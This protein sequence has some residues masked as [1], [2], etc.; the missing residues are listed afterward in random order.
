MA[1]QGAGVLQRE[2]LDVDDVRG[3]PGGLHRRLA[4]LDVLG[5]GR[6]QQHVQHVGILVGGTD[7]LVVV[8]DLFHREGDVL[9]GLHLDLTLEFVF[10]EGLRH[11]DDFG[12]RGIAADRDRRQAALRAGALHCAP[13]GLADGFRIDDGLLVDGVVR[14]RLRG[15]R[16]N[17]VLSP[18][19][20][21]LDELHGGSGNVQSQ[22]RTISFAKRPH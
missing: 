14:R 17:A 9:V 5:A 18:R 11:L 2:G 12:D 15:I 6:D 16:L 8:A 3:Q 10:A 4:L 21:E 22:Q 7:D 13:D 20:R 1:H 19:H